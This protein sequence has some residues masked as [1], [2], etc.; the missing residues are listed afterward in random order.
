MVALAIW[1]GACA[2]PE[3]RAP[4]GGALPPTPEARLAVLKQDLGALRRVDGTMTMGDADIRYSAYFDARALRYVN[5]RIAMGDYGSAVAEYYLENGQLRY[6]RQEARLTAMEPGAA[7][8]TV[9]QVEFELWF[10]AEGNLAG[11]ERTVDGRLTRVPET[12]IQGALRH[13]E[14]L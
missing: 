7:P 12:E 9:R 3:R 2:G 4:L 14:V 11:W 6:H 8:G 1:V 10:D 5:E 13:W